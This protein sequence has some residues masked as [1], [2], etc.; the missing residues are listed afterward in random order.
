VKPGIGQR[1]LLREMPHKALGG[2]EFLGFAF[3]F[4]SIIRGEKNNQY[5]K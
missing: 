5:Q 1:Q 3:S 2:S 4:W